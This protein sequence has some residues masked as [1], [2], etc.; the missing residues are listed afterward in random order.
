MLLIRGHVGG[1]AL[2]GTLYERGE[3]PP[4]FKGAPDE[5]AP[6]VW[7]CDAFYEVESGGQR[8]QLG[9]RD[10]RIAFESPMPRGFETKAQAIAAAKEHVRTQFA[11]LGVVENSVEIE[12][13]K[14]E[15]GV[16]S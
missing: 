12:V 4:S 13:V 1:T 10:L 8:Q 16:E 15:P 9:D 5:G 11:R 3:D 14:Q 6:Y 2:T 7:V